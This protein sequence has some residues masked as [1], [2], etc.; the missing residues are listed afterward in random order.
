MEFGLARNWWVLA[1][2]GV[3]ALLFGVLAFFWPGIAWLVVVYTFAAYAL[4]DGTVAIVAAVT[5]HGEAGRWW[6]LLLEGVV[7]LVAGVLA[8]AWPAI[9][10]VALL[11]LIAAWL[12]VTGLFEIVTAFALWRQIPGEWAMALAGP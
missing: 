4:I 3:L 1:L 12:F 10:Q 8:F 11:Y 5:G 6:A 7:G 2:R 9:T